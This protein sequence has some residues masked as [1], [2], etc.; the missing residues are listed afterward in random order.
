MG[1]QAMRLLTGN[2]GNRQ[3]PLTGKTEKTKKPKITATG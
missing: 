3:Q 2:T 1:V